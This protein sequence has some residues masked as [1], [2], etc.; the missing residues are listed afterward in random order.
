MAQLIDDCFASAGRPISIAQAVALIAERVA[1]VARIETVPI[2]FADNRI[3]ARDVFALNPLPNFDNSAMDGYAVR[4]ADL[5]SEGESRLALRGRIPAGS[6]PSAADLRGGAV[7]IFT[8]APMPEGTD[9]VFMQE[10]VRLDGGDVW[11]PAG[12]KRGA[13]RR[14]AGED[15]PQGGLVIPAGRR[16]RPQ[17]LA[18]AAAAGHASI[19]VRRSLR[20]AVFSTGDELIE[21]GAPLRPGAI[22][23][24]NRVMISALL[25]RFGAEVCDLGILRDERAETAHALEEAAR[26]HDLLLTSGGVS[27]GEEDHVKAAVESVGRLVFWR[28]AIKPGRPVAMGLVRDTPFVGLPGNPVAAYV[29]LLFVV[30]ALVDR[31]GGAI[32]ETPRAL[33]TR[34]GF[35]HTKKRGR[36]EFLRVFLALADDGEIEARAFPKEESGA[37]RSL[38]GSDGLAELAD[39]VTA[40][41]IGDAVTFHPHAALW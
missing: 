8:G 31:L 29:T 35:A 25:R 11:L 28:L 40:L 36:R 32:H 12:L 6:A 10:D 4:H 15:V 17:D 30:R 2:G 26:D 13:N 9:T 34:A 18:I 20:V 3:A 37:F 23:D 21:P 41:E 5:A 39:D 33:R 22:F 24:A 14:R 27:I 38:T 7:R 1:V 19:D 16:L